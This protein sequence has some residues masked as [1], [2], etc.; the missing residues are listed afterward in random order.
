[1]PRKMICFI[2]EKPLNAEERRD[3][4]RDENGDAL[5][6]ECYS[7]EYEAPCGRCHNYYDMLHW[8]HPVHFIAFPEAQ[9]AD[10]M[11]VPGY[12]RVLRYPLWTS[13]YFTTSVEMR[14]VVKVADLRGDDR[15]PGNAPCVHICMDCT[16]EVPM[17]P[18]IPVQPFPI[19][20][21]EVAIRE[22]RG[23]G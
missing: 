21:V 2:C 13:D 5:C 22:E 17:L 12:Y 8:R 20:A 10:E 15:Q 4:K 23:T 3:P 11:L 7:S 19:E 9:E 6:D 16:A 14:N 1:M 18:P